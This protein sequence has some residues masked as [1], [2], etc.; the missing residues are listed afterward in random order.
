MR[1]V[2]MQLAAGAAVAIFLA[3]GCGGSKKADPATPGSTTVTEKSAPTSGGGGLDDQATR[4]G[5]LYADNCASCHGDKGEG[6]GG[7]PPV[8]GKDALPL[9]P[10]K[11]ADDRKGKFANA[12]DVFDFMKKYMPADKP[13]S[14]KDSE[15]WDI[16]GFDLKANGVD[17]SGK[18]VD[19]SNAASIKLH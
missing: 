11:G 3:V 2:A 15:Y 8:V 14:L 5:K 1:N 19:A 6:G 9:D 13:S 16:L 7:G 10:P 4:G 12:Q 18:A 17:T